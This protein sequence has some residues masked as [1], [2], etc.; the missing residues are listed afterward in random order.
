MRFLRKW[1]SDIAQYVGEAFGLGF[2]V[3]GISCT[4]ESLSQRRKCDG[5][6]SLTW[7][8][9]AHGFWAE[10]RRWAAL[11]LQ[12]ATLSDFTLHSIIQCACRSK[13]QCSIQ[14]CRRQSF[15]IVG[16][17][18]RVSSQALGLLRIS[19]KIWH[20]EGSSLELPSRTN[21]Y[22]LGSVEWLLMDTGFN[23]CEWW[24]YSNIDYGD[25]K[26]WIY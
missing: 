10:F 14:P 17:P 13:F 26:L 2:R 21:F 24:K 12:K 7:E 19:G 3:K 20:I 25:V 23:S 11:W 9:G 8:S 15:T 1:I 4:F 22:G 18:T 5:G 16:V 6:K